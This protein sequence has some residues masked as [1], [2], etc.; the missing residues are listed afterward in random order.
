MSGEKLEKK[1]NDER[2]LTLRN[3]RAGVG[4]LQKGRRWVG[5]W[6]NW[7]TGIKEGM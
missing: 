2:L 1:T 6:G 3:E 7:M 5:R 4:G